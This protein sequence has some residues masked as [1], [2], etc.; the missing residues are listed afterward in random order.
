MADI[1]AIYSTE[2]ASVEFYD[3][4]TWE[5]KSLNPLYTDKGLWKIEQDRLRYTCNGRESWKDVDVFTLSEFTRL[6]AEY[7]FDRQLAELLGE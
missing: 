3:N 6:C 4:G 2:V 1:I 5:Q 7:K